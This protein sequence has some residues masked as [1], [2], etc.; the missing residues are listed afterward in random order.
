MEQKKYVTFM[1]A[2]EALNKLMAEKRLEGV[3]LLDKNNGRIL[4]KAY[5]R[6]PIKR[7]KDRL[8]KSLLTGWVKEST[9]NYKI[10]QSIPK[11]LGMPRVLGVVDSETIEAKNA[12]MEHEIIDRV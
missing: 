10:F 8:I 11:I 1:N 9:E 2:V 12:L 7:K 6:K 3:M 5:N 4:F